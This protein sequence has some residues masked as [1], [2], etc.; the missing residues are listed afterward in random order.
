VR[1]ARDTLYS[2]HINVA[3]A[4]WI[5][6]CTGSLTPSRRGI[7]RRVF[8]YYSPLHLSH[9][10]SL[11]LAFSRYSLLYLIFSRYP[12]LHLTRRRRRDAAVV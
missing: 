6:G 11:R 1:R 9:Y 4:G 8:F 3:R 7:A 10:L 12:P 5:D 2:S